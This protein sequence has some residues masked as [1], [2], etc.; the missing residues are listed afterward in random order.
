M[1]PTIQPCFFP[2]TQIPQK[3]IHDVSTYDQIRPPSSEISI[4]TQKRHE[5]LSNI[6]VHECTTL[7]LLTLPNYTNMN[8][9][10]RMYKRSWWNSCDF[11]CGFLGTH[12]G[13]QKW[14]ESTSLRWGGKRNPG[15]R[16]PRIQK[17]RSTRTVKRYISYLPSFPGRSLPLLTNGGWVAWWT[18]RME[19]RMRDGRNEWSKSSPVRSF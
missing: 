2:S 17:H 11:C 13:T 3:G 1:I 18:W 6:W 8:T 16:G 10:Q 9:V 4:D 12:I 5:T 19:G 7:C 14:A 15:I